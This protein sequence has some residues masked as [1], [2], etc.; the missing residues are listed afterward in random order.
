M[1]LSPFFYAH[2]HYTKQPQCDSGGATADMVE[3]CLYLYE[4]GIFIVPLLFLFDSLFLSHTFF[5]C[6]GPA[7]IGLSICMLQ[8]SIT[9]LLTCSF[10]FLFFFF[11]GSF[12]ERDF[13]YILRIFS[14][15]YLF[16]SIKWYLNVLAFLAH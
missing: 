1:S 2:T 4:I 15:D 10:I 3:I 16:S 6:L 11:F 13:A 14:A 9:L 12:Y 5:L 8:I 7:S